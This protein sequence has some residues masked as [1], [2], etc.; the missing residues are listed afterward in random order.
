MAA[1]SLVAGVDASTQATKVVVVDPASGRV[2]ATGRARHTVSG[3]GGARETDPRQW[4]RA[5]RTA[6]AATGLARDIGAIAIGGQQH[7]LVVL[8]ALGRPLRK[9]MLWNDTRSADD[10]RRLVR[11]LGAGTWAARVGSRP[12][13]SFTV[14][15]WAWLRRVEPDVARATAAIRLPHD[16]LTELLTGRGVTDR[17]DAS[18]TGWYSTADERYAEDILGA[19]GVEL[20]AELL[21]AVLGPRE[22][23]GE[24]RGKAARELGLR[25]GVVVGPGT[26]DNAAAA[27]GL[28]LG[29]GQAALSL[30]TSGT[31]FAVSA[32]RPDDASG[33]VAGFADAGGRFLPLAATL[34]C[35][36]A[37]DRMASLLRLRREDVEPA[38]RRGR[39]ALLRRRTDT[40]P[41]SRGR[42]AHRAARRHD[43]ATD[44]DGQLRGRGCLA[45]RCPRR[46]GRAMRRRRPGGAA[47]G[48][49]RWR[50]RS[51]VARGHRSVVGSRAAH[52]RR[53]GAGGTGGG[54]AGGGGLA[55]GGT[56]AVARRWDTSAGTRI[57]AVPRDEERLARIRAV[58]GAVTRA[59]AFSRP[60]A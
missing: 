19:P 20:Q 25:D 33:T 21:P 31:V 9:A 10:A 54:G 42:H 32:R 49:R 36:L 30:G 28:G 53:T 37:V 43:A 15:K 3:T 59:P 56:G 16:Y 5:L 29:V 40:G 14:T 11:L 55:R 35:T 7:G 39:A 27:M 2:L 26:G 13:A 48:G 38:G 6:L 60:D 41:A 18:G 8:D 23:A 44:A 17:G 45:H 34:N 50:P 1:G 24:V 51:G 58:L 22:V 4:W 47:D 46:G 57:A 12:V 52:P